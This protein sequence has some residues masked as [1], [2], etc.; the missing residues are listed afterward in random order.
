MSD[1]FI[2]YKREN[3]AAVNRLVEALRAEGVSAWWDQDIAPNAPWEATIERELAAAKLVVVAWSPASVASDNVKA[4]ARWARGQGRL[5][6][7]FVEACEP[8]LFFGERQGVDLKGW[9]GTAADPAFRS[10]LQAVRAGPTPTPEAA[11]TEAPPTS[12]HLPS[13][14][15]IAVMPF[16]NLSGDPEQEYFADGMVAEITNALSRFKSLFVIAS[17]STLTFKGKAT[18]AQEAAKQLG[19]RFVLE[20]SVRK[21]GSRVRISVQLID[22]ADGAQV[23]SERFD[24]T[25]EDVFDL[26]DKVALAVAG[27][28]EPTVREADARR[29]VARPTE[30]MGSYDL[31]LRSLPHA[32]TGGRAGNLKALEF[33]RK[34][35]TLDASYG[36]AL[37]LTAN[38][39]STTILYGW[40]DDLDADRREA[41]RLAQ[42]ALYVAGDDGDVVATVA[43]E[44]MMAEGDL[45]TAIPLFDRAVDLNPGSAFAWGASGWCRLSAD[46]PVLAYDHFSTAN[47]LDPTSP[48]RAT[49]A[50]GMGLALFAQKRFS[51][52]VSLL[53]QSAQAMPDWP[54]SF[55]GLA[56]CYAL[57]GD[58]AAA[59]DAIA[60]HD[61]LT[62]VNMRDWALGSWS[63]SLR[64]LFLEAIDLAEGKLAAQ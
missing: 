28:I 11:A 10:L 4:E 24:D 38:V 44:T 40:S 23:W 33:L 14:P 54:L 37:G 32:R 63:Q 3:L 57:L 7:V 20:G 25:L 41:K 59:R 29:V 26:Q 17:S 52:A 53:K 62:P 13:K 19:V 35:I 5:L 9:S 18:G 60:R 27:K 58:V 31:Y 43:F 56:A 48:D 15:S 47:R 64:G 36:V 21:A 1:V 16:A 55:A 50:G 61:S 8:P 39:L 51:D 2:S 6:Q 46:E 45:I 12:L 42:Q 34:A 22:A 30:N 49:R